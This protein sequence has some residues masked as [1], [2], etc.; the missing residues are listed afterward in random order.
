MD[1]KVFFEFTGERER[2]ISTSN[3]QFSVLSPHFQRGGGGDGEGG[4]SW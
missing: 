4:E 1:R 2:E 3:F